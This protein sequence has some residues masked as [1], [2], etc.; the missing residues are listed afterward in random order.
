VQSPLT[1]GGFAGAARSC[2]TPGHMNPRPEPAAVAETAPPTTLAELRAELD[3]VDDQL[4]DLLMHRAAVIDRVARDGGKTG[5]KIRPGREA[6]M[7]RRLLARHEGS[8]PPQTIVRFWR[9][10][11]AGALIIE[12]G[13]TV[14]VCN[15]DES[16]ELPALAR[17]HFG[18]LTPLRKHS[19]PAQ[20]LAD[21][22]RGTAQVAVLPPPSDEPDG[23]WWTALMGTGPRPLSVIGKLPFWTKRPEGTPTGEAY[24][25]ATLRP[26]E[27]GADRGLIALELSAD[28]SRARINTILTAAGFAPG[29]IW[30]KRVS[31]ADV[32]ALVEVDGLVNDD[33]PRLEQI[34]GLHAPASVIGGFAV[35]LD[36][37]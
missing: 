13:Q 18:P 21:I 15:G 31:D 36:A 33:D 1:Q 34:T 6:S 4:H 19:N 3:A 26:D 37:T 29:S 28:I 30:L 10:I 25:V 5:V 9:E 11:F 17:E 24:I 22:E 16:A 12:G 7:L 23:G 20:A 2:N 14:A 27:S 35:P 32:L 8:M